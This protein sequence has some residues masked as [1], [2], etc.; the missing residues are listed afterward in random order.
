VRALQAIGYDGSVVLEV[1]PPGPNPFQSI[2][3]KQSA[4]ILDGYIRESL[5]LLRQ[6]WATL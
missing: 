5:T 3:D 4:G 1:M 2:K 6:H